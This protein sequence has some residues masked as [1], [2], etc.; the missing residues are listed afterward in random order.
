MGVGVVVGRW[1]MVGAV[2]RQG[3]WQVGWQRFG[4]RCALC[5]SRIDM[6]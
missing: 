2:M 4:L 5:A 1:V 3:T 6:T